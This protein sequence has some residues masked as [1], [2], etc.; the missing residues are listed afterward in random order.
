MANCMAIG[1][2]DR[3]FTSF[4]LF[5][6]A[7]WLT[8]VA[9]P[10]AVGACTVLQ[11][12]FDPVEAGALIERERITSVRQMVHDE[13]RLVAAEAQLPHDL[14]TVDVGIVTEPLRALTSMT[15]EPAEICAWGM[16]ETFAIATFLPFD[17]PL[18]LRRATMGSP[19]PGNQIRI[20][21]QVSGKTLGPGEVGEITVGGISLMRGYY[22][23][24]DPLP[25]D[26][27][28]FL[29]TGD[30]GQLRDDGYL[31]FAGRLDRLIKTAGVNVSPVEIEEHLLSWGRV[32]TC[33]V[34]GVP[35]PTLG[36]AVVL[37][38]ARRADGV[39]PRESE[40]KAALRSL[41]PSFKVPHSILFFDEDELTLTSSSKVDVQALLPRAIA[42]LL[43]SDMDDVWRAML[44]EWRDDDSGA[45]SNS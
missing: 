20:R 8:G 31:V 26:E 35:H 14:S 16:T 6:T 28:G 33:A 29:R 36:T 18:E 19:A 39:N 44:R 41:L 45:I 43:E 34:I 30:A 5:W 3:A 13:H 22:K 9:A 32:G 27:A 23:A 10:F 24:E 21:D 42:R 12:V 4:P 15:A 40:I 7:G 17:A 2:N 11:E 1:S 25:T 37:C 38:A